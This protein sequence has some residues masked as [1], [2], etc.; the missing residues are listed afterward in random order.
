MD[1]R[2][3]YKQKAPGHSRHMHVSDNLG[4]QEPT[5][6]NTGRL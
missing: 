2:M 4:T 1:V 5:T 3:V 6:D